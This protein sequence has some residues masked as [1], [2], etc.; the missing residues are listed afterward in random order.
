MIKQTFQILQQTLSAATGAAEVDYYLGQYQPGEG[1]VWH[2]EKGV[3]IEFADMPT[4]QL[5]GNAQQIVARIRIHCA[6]SCLYDDGQR[7]TDATVNHLGFVED[8]YKALNGKDFYL[9]LLPAYAA[10][11]GTNDDRIVINTMSRTA[12]VNDH[13]LRSV[14][15]TV[16]EFSC[17]I[18]DYSAML[19]LIE[20]QASLVVNASIA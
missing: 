12:I 14:L 2:V 19:E 20:K 5:G 17:T 1:D 4:E 18:Y 11:A 7:I 13:A 16:Q 9:S 8:A 10:L 3:Y 15:A 6:S